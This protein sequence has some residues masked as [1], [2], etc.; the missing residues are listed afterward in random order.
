MY[1]ELYH[2]GV[3]GMKWGIRRYQNE[4]GTLT[5]KGRKHLENKASKLE[6]LYSKYEK[7]DAQFNK[8]Y[9]KAVKISPITHKT[10]IDSSKMSKAKNYMAMSNRI[11][12]K[13]YKTYNRTIKKYGSTAISEIPKFEEVGSRFE[14]ANAKSIYSR[15]LTTMFS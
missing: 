15:Q 1:N 3:L 4:D 2:Y 14:S 7:K 5:D 11:T 8:Y 13:G 12:N 10:K 9:N 6:R